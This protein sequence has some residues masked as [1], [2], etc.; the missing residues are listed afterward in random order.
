MESK[1]KLVVFIVVIV[2]MLGLLFVLNGASQKAF[3][4]HELEQQIKIKNLKHKQ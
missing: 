4:A 2:I 1:K 3:E